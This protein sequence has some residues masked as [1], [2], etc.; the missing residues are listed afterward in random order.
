MREFTREA[1]VAD[2]GSIDRRKLGAIVFADKAR[3]AA[4][5]NI[6]WPRIR[7][8][9]EDQAA[10]IKAEARAAGVCVCVCVCVC[11]PSHSFGV[12]HLW[13]SHVSQP[14]SVCRSFCR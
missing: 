5:C 2:D 4:L 3:M 6:L 9:I 10:Q 11:S 8:R 14:P 13:C 1:V 7:K 12:A